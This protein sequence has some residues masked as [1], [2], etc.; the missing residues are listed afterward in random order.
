MTVRQFLGV[1]RAGRLAR[2]ADKAMLKAYGISWIYNSQSITTMLTA[3]SNLVAVDVSS[4]EQA[5]RVAVADAL[6]AISLG[7]PEADVQVPETVEEPDSVV[8]QESDQRSNE[9]DEMF[10]VR[11]E[12]VEE[13][14]PADPQPQ[15]PRFAEVSSPEEVSDLKRQEFVRHFL[16]EER[17]ARGLPVPN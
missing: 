9:A 12:M 17:A 5:I 8:A 11:P 3:P 4:L 15:I 10:S 16:R 2:K 1:R 14:P 6:T 7:P 13:A